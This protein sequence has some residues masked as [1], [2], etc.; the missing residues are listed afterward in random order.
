MVFEQAEFEIRCE[1]GEQGIRQLA[2]M[3][4]VI[5]IVDILS[6]STCVEVAVSQ[7]AIVFPYRWKDRSAADYARSIDAD[8]ASFDRSSDRP[9]LSPDSLFN[10]LPASRLVLPSPNG[11]TLSLETGNTTTIAGCLRNCQAVAQAIQACETVAVIPAGERW[12]DGTLRPAVEDWIGA[13][14]ILSYLEGKMSPEAQAAVAAFQACSDLSLR[15]HQCSSG[16]EL[17]AKGFSRDVELAAQ[18][19]VSQSVPVLTKTS[20][21]AAAAHTVG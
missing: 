16:K 18:L 20:R 3:S 21:L 5:V 7:G 15:L 19:N 6:F 8:L 4:Q 17:I 9:S 10:L 11:A 13:G 2:P 12:P 14:A 1:W